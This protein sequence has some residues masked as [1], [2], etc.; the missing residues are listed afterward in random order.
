MG[1]S[2]RFR[3]WGVRLSLSLSIFI[4]PIST[5]LPVALSIYLP[6][7]CSIYP[8][9]PYLQRCNKWSVSPKSSPKSI[10]WRIVYPYFFS[11]GAGDS[12]I[13]IHLVWLVQ[14]R[15]STFYPSRYESYRPNKSPHFV[16]P[17]QTFSNMFPRIVT[18]FPT[19]GSYF[20]KNFHIIQELP[21][22]LANF[23]W[24]LPVLCP[25]KDATLVHLV[26]HVLPH[27]DLDD[28]AAQPPPP[29]GHRARLE[30]WLERWLARTPGA[31]GSFEW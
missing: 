8:T 20:P 6:P 29:S 19:I 14:P 22:F 4:Y 7:S 2:A 15:C 18:C 25:V 9:S 12:L 26:L 31:G 16:P 30:R 28:L 27:H 3:C 11:F 5:C 13:Y 23:P 1:E 21:G 17:F 10:H 24:L